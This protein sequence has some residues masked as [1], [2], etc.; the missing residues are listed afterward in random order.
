MPRV[1][2]TYLCVVCWFMRRLIKIPIRREAKAKARKPVSQEREKMRLGEVLDIFHENFTMKSKDWTPA[3]KK[4]EN[5]CVQNFT[6]LTAAVITAT[7]FFNLNAIIRDA[8]RDTYPFNLFF[9]SN[10]RF[11]IRNTQYCSL[12]GNI[13]EFRIYKITTDFI[14]NACILRMMM[15]CL[16][17]HER[18]NAE[19]NWITAER[20]A[21]VEP[22]RTESPVY[23]RSFWFVFSD[24]CCFTFSIPITCLNVLQ[25]FKWGERYENINNRYV[26]N[27]HS[28][29]SLTLFILDNVLC[30]LIFAL[31]CGLWCLFRAAN[32]T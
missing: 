4:I 32:Q 31:V 15:R 18:I 6:K 12:F 17:R 10:L 25:L 11:A 5:L 13:G 23:Q 29:V 1:L 19:R 27:M 20:N 8:I 22:N 2:F 3:V 21:R 28:F 24:C 26:F 9:P 16:E 14:L 30:Y 7:D